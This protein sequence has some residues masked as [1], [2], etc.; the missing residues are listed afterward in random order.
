ME[1]YKIYITPS[2]TTNS[3]VNLVEWSSLILEFVKLSIPIKKVH[4][5]G[6]CNSEMLER[7]AE[8]DPLKE[9]KTDPRWD[10]LKDL[11]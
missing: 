4:E 5:D 8:F 3:A 7:I 11:L 10:G 1:F 6:E 9:E 2:S